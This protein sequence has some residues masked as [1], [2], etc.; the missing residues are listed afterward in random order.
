MH[1]DDRNRQ[2]TY[3]SKAT[4]F[5]AHAN[6]ISDTAKLV[7]E[8]GASN[9]R[10]LVEELNNKAQ[11]VKDLAPQVVAA[12][13]VLLLNPGEQVGSVFLGMGVQRGGR[14]MCLK[15]ICYPSPLPQQKKNRKK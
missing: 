7:A 6:K 9:D 14:G 5:L 1:V 11:E 12:G 15:L 10:P 8:A 13:K 2:Q 3:T 4:I